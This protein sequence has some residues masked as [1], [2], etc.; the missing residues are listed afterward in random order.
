MRGKIQR[1]QE[2]A[3]IKNGRMT[4]A[5]EPRRELEAT[6]TAAVEDGNLDEV[7]AINHVQR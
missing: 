3:E 1:G 5:T 4:L 7:G 6:T 2:K